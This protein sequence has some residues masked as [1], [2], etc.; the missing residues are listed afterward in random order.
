MEHY[1]AAIIGCGGRARGHVEGYQE[2]R[3]EG[4]CV[5]LVAVADIDRERADRFAAEHAARAYYDAAEMLERE[6]PHLVSIVTKP[7]GRADLACLCADRGVL[8]IVAEKPMAITLEEADRMVAA[9]EKAGT[10]LTVCHQMRY[11][12]E[13]ELGKQAIAGGAIGEVY[14]LRGVCYGNLM[15][16]GTHV[17]DMLRWFADDAP[18]A[19]VMAQA[20]DFDWRERDPG[21]PAPM[22]TVGYFA[23]QNGLR[24]SLE[25]GPRYVPAAG[26]KPGWLNKRVEALGTEGML[27][28]VVGNYMRL[29]STTPTPPPPAPAGTRHTPTPSAWQGQETGV[30]GWNRATIR[31][32]EDLVRVLREGGTHRNNA[33]TS[34]HSFEVIQ[35]LA[36]SVLR[37]EAVE[38]PLPRDGGDPLGELLAARE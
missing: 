14:F 18:I 13:F 30:E 28:C 33:A 9:C 16:Q 25:A 27:D 17:I 21:H 38:L 4:A 15:Q 24:A 8:G 10:V 29:L 12:P 26:T 5:E 20:A 36:L 34:L 31:F 7:A 35:A 19:W 11:S 6:K 37:G 1:R 23:F 32:I 22:W 3:P 2:A